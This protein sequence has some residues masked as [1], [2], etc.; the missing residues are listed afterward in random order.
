[1]RY[2]LVVLLLS[3]SSASFSQKSKDTVEYLM[4]FSKEKCDKK[5][6]YYYR[7]A[8]K[9]DSQWEVKDYYL[10]TRTIAFSGAF[11]DDSFHIQEGPHFS[12]HP[13]GKMETKRRYWNGKREGLWKSYND[14]GKLLDSSLYLHDMPWRFSYKWFE[15]GIL[16][17]KG[18]YDDSGKG[19][20]YET[21][22]YEDGTIGH[23]SK[24]D[25]GY[26]E[27]SIWVFNFRNGKPS[28]IE[29]YNKGSLLKRECFTLQGQ[30]DIC[31]TSLKV[32][33][34]SVI[35]GQ[36]YHYVE[37]MPEAPYDVN[38]FLGQNIQY[39]EKARQRDIEGRI[40]V[41]F[42]VAEDGSI[43]DVRIPDHSD[44]GIDLEKEAI[45]VVSIMPKWNPGK[46][47]NRPVK[48]YYHLPVVFRLE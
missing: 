18:V 3:I 6:A 25:V 9:V 27:D 34:S 41:Q 44:L 48:V 15:S 43:R 21:G 7:L 30:H 10:T 46:E 31:D 33:Y 20:G 16:S 28:C 2:I 19:A 1:M 37:K 47:H 42:V 24:Y 14:R 17:F 45:R 4:N 32:G 38:R 23:F 12:Y 29:Y 5:V 35:I 11:S 8:Y 26:K 36:V 22:F 39:P 13:N 40:S